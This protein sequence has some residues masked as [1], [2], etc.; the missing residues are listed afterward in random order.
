MFKNSCSILYLYYICNNLLMRKASDLLMTS[1][2]FFSLSKPSFLVE[3]R[4]WEKTVFLLSDQ[5][6]KI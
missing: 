3:G 6:L 1:L 5:N 4:M 2:I